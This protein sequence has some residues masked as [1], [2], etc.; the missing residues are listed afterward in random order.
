M[1]L[2]RVDPTAM[3]LSKKINSLNAEA[4]PIIAS[5][6]QKSQGRF[7]KDIHMVTTNKIYLSVLNLGYHFLDISHVFLNQ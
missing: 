6:N 1:A 3:F 4:T 2:L 7:D 5:A